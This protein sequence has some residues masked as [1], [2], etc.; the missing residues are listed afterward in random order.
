MRSSTIWTS[1]ADTRNLVYYCHTQHNRRVRAVELNEIDS[2]SLFPG[3]MF[4]PLDRKKEQDVE[5]LIVG[6]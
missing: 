3:A 6:N 1:A 2:G 5:V 4:Y